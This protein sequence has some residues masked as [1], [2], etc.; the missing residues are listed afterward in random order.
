[1]YICQYIIFVTF[2]ITLPIHLQTLTQ[3]YSPLNAVIPIIGEEGSKIMCH[4]QGLINKC[5]ITQLT[6]L[7]RINMYH[8]VVSD[9]ESTSAVM[10]QFRVKKSTLLYLSYLLFAPTFS[11]SFRICETPETFIVSAL[12]LPDYQIIM[13]GLV[14]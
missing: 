11:T 5:D 10:I 3:L 6:L 14:R 1:M 7:Q 8:Y 13:A 12:A 2:N 9:D 4:H